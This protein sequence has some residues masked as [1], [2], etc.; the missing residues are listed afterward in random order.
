MQD[1]E[2]FQSYESEQLDE[3]DGMKEGADSTGR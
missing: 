2:I 3:V 1:E